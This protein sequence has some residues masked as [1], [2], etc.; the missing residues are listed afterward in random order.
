M[1]KAASGLHMQNPGNL[2][3]KDGDERKRIIIIPTFMILLT[4]FCSD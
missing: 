1:Q 2:H 4:G 3:R